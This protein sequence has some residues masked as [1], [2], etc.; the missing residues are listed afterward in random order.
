MPKRIILLLDGT[1]ND[2][3]A[4]GLS[5][6]NIVRLREIIASCL[7]PTPL[8]KASDALTPA[9]SG[10]QYSVTTR[11]YSSGTAP[12]K[13]HLIFYERGVGTSGFLNSI[14]GGAFAV[15]LARTIRRAY[16][17]LA[18]N[19]EENDEIFIF[20]FSRGSYTARSLVGYVGAIGLLKCEC[21]NPENESESLV[22]LS[23]ESLRSAPIHRNRTRKV[24]S[25]CF[26]HT[27]PL[28]WCFRHGRCFGSAA[29]GILAGKP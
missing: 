28:S 18:R 25:S 4:K 19:Y 16:I 5:D 10:H 2:A 9:S 7:D 29:T 27:H 23:T 21:C 20:G 15:E 17:F 11:N 22:L 12:A 3:D 14:G 26:Q 1:W 8:S 6:T 13:T 24:H